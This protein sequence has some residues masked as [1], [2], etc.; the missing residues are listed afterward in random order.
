M[1][2][3]HK[4]TFFQSL[5]AGGVAGTSVD[6]LFFPIDT[7]KTRLQSS[8]G[9]AKA[10]GFRGVYKGI[11]SVVVG[12]APGA[13]AFFSTY[14]T[15]KHALPLHGHLAPVNHMISASMAEVAACLIRVPTEVIKTRTQTSTYGPL[16]SS[17]LAAAKLVWKHDG[18][19][20][21][22]RGFGTTI[23]REIPFTSLQFPLYELLKLQLSH[24][25]GRKP[26][27]AHEA[28]VCGSIAGGTAAA[29]T[30]PLDVLKT[31]VMLDL[32]DPSQRLPSVASRFRQIYVNE[33]VNA[34]FAGVVPRTMWISAGGAV[35][36]G[37]YEWAVHGLMGW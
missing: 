25:L 18:W 19:R 24:R 2:K 33:G 4:P 9:F 20:G 10:G 21:Y 31:R 35:F 7:I 12:S 17:S 6:L 23:M 11:G 3:G 36:L 32:R 16:A 29:L 1:E 28:A 5:A 14:E 15:M 26:L 27:Y 22:Y 34:L 8:Q 37:V 13:A 30:T